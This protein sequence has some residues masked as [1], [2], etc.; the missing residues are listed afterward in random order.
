MKIAFSLADWF[1]QVCCRSQEELNANTS[2]E[3]MRQEEVNFFRTHDDLGS[4]PNK[5]KGMPALVDKL[6]KLQGQHIH[7]H[8]PVLKK[9]VS[10]LATLHGVDAV[11]N[12]CSMS[13]RLKC[14]LTHKW[15]A[16]LAQDAMA[17]FTVQIA[18]VSTEDWL[19][20]GFT[21]TSHVVVL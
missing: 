6:V 4:L 16:W 17:I 12:P 5:N 8:I 15:H 11:F 9:Q 18:Y 21:C 20:I 7:N 2:F 13:S 1:M 10:S 19:A 3:D 14:E